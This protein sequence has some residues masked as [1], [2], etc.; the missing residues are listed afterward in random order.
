MVMKGASLIVVLET[1]LLPSCFTHL[2]GKGQELVAISLKYQ[3][4][5]EMPVLLPNSESRVK[6]PSGDPYHL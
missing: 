5:L 1:L 6:G 4:C 2:E 3:G